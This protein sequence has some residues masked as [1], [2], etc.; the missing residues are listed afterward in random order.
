MYQLLKQYCTERGRVSPLKEESYKDQKLGMWADSQRR[1]YKQQQKGKWDNR[2]AITI[3]DQQIN[4][5]TDIDFIWDSEKAEQ[6]CRPE[7]TLWNSM[8]QLLNDYRTEH[9]HILISPGDLYQ[10]Q[11]LGDWVDAQ[12]NNYKLWQKGEL[13][14]SS[15]K[16]AGLQITI[17]NEIGFIWEERGVVQD[18][19]TSG[20][21]SSWDSMYQLL[22]DYNIENKHVCPCSKETYRD[23]NLGAWVNRQRSS[24]RNRQKGESPESSIKMSDE[25]M[26]LLNEIGFLW[27]IRRASDNSIRD[28]SKWGS[29]YQLLKDYRAEHN[30]HVSP[31]RG[32]I[33]MGRNLGKWV[34]QQ[35]TA[36]NRRL[37]GKLGSSSLI[38][39]DQR[40]ALLNELGFVWSER[41][42]RPCKSL[43]K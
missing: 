43:G 33:Y 32:E 14:E 12:R 7:G 40:L 30:N 39:S 25:R 31:A 4:L 26:A 41:K 5:L 34:D 38:M 13:D 29:M 17:L 8:Y 15:M 10:G 24:Y 16:L 37:K 19:T 11:N 28:E 18:S 20:E 36:Y 2:S 35:R 22:K 3:S 9:K 1:R 27:E 23:Q 21:A 42:P 6:A